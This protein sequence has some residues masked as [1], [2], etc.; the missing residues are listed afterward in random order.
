[1]QRMF[2]QQVK[3]L[4]RKLEQPALHRILKLV[5]MGYLVLSLLYSFMYFIPGQLYRHRRS[6]PQQQQSSS[7]RV[8]GKILL[9]GHKD[10][11]QDSSASTSIWSGRFSVIT[12]NDLNP[13]QDVSDDL[14]YSKLFQYALKPS[15]IIPYF[16]RAEYKPTHTDITITT[17]ITI[18]RLHVLN[19]LVNR[20]LGT[21]KIIR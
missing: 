20:F 8:M 11:A 1:M 9:N 14:L 7:A 5:F 3:W 13:L 19:N 4:Q 21:D 18:E 6:S 15:K 10:T 16:F 2:Q 17:M 12:E